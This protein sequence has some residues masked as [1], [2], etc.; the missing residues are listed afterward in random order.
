MGFLD[1]VVT[2]IINP[3]LWGRAILAI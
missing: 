2:G 1:L 3:L